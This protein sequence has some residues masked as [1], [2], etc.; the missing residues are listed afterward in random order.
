MTSK[1]IVEEFLAL[2]D[3]KDGLISTYTGEV[4]TYKELRTAIIDCLNQAME[5]G[6]KN[7]HIEAE[8][9]ALYDV[10]IGGHNVLDVNGY[11]FEVKS[12]NEGY[13]KCMSCTDRD[14]EYVR[15]YL[16]SIIYKADNVLYGKS[17][18]VYSTEF[19]NTEL[20]PSGHLNTP[21]FIKTTGLL[22]SKHKLYGLWPTCINDDGTIEFTFD[23][24][25][26]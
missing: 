12:Y 24:I 1:Q 8:A 16:D 10:T 18:K 3:D 25:L 7:G 13:I 15:R 5:D 9:A 6:Y 2:L 14:Q 26:K 19:D 20:Y 23:H 4:V 11:M 22:D 17:H 21:L